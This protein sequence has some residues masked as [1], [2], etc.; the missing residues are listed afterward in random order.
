MTVPNKDSGATAVASTPSGR[1]G[2]ILYGQSG[3]VVSFGDATWF[4]DASSIH[5]RGGTWPPFGSAIDYFSGSHRP[6]TGAVTGSSVSTA[7]CSPSEML[8]T[9]GRWADS[10]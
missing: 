9:T 3:R 8:P 2:W 6:R 4:G 7:G 10:M 1:G 5:H